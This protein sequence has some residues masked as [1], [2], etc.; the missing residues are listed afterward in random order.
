MPSILNRS[1]FHDEGAAYEM[2]ESII[3]PHGPVCPHCGSIGHSSRLAGKAARIGLL[4]CYDCRKQ[5]TV[6]VGT[7]FE[8]SH[9]CSDAQ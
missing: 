8:S 5:F 9:I 4:K 7:V 6:K 3:W 2:L 1:Y